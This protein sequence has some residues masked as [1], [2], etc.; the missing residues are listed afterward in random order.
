[1]VEG[2]GEDFSEIEKAMNDLFLP[3]LFVDQLDKSGPHSTLSK[4]PVKFA[5]L[6]LPNPVASS[7]TNFE[8][9]TLLVYSHL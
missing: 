7:D 3:S 2:I 4:L 9:S 5:G 1:M 8:A 6:V